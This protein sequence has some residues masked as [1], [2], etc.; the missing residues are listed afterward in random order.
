MSEGMEDRPLEDS[1][2]RYLAEHN[3]SSRGESAGFSSDRSQRCRVMWSLGGARAQITGVSELQPHPVG[4]GDPQG[5]FTAQ[6]RLVRVGKLGLPLVTPGCTSC[7]HVRGASVA[8]LIRARIFDKA[9]VGKN[10]A[11]ENN[12]GNGEREMVGRY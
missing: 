5:A 11:R 7:R 10:G 3:G 2:R 9:F 8:L 4:T 12:T 6:V 1:G